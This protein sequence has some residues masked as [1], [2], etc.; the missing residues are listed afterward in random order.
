MELLNTLSSN[1]SLIATTSTPSSFEIDFK[2]PL[3]LAPTPI[4]AVL[5]VFNF[6]AEKSPI[7]IPFES[8]ITVELSQFDKVEA[9]V[10]TAA[11]IVVVLINF[12]L[13]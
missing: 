5:I 8:G 9:A 11:D 1:K 6:G 12:L 10:N 7:Y 4:N 13:L 3:P 2:C